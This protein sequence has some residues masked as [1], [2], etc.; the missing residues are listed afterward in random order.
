MRGLVERATHANDASVPT[1]FAYLGDLDPI[2][3]RA[4]KTPRDPRANSAQPRSSGARSVIALT[5]ALAWKPSSS[6]TSA[7]LR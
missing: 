6:G 4:A 3:P 2:R 1:G 7:A 5:T